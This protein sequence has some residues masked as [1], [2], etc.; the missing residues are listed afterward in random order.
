MQLWFASRTG[1]VET[2]VSKLALKNVKRIFD[3]NEVATEEYILFT[4]TDGVGEVP[5]VVKAFLELNHNLLRGVIGSGNKNFGQN[6]CKSV[7]VISE[8]YNVPILM[9]FDLGGNKTA[10]EELKRILNEMNLV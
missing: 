10:I 9:K 8:K 7:H 4:Y 3:G 6:F 1:K 2:I 5:K